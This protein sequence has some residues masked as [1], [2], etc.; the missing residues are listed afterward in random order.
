MPKFLLMLHSLVGHPF[1]GLSKSPNKP[2]IS[3][4]CFSYRGTGR[5]SHSGPSHIL[6]VVESGVGRD[7]LV[8]DVKLV[9]D[10]LNICVI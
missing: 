3:E 10:P 5:R 1:E 7:D 9:F 2:V 6:Y 8:L 4:R